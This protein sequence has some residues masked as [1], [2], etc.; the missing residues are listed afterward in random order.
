[1]QRGEPFGL[2]VLDLVYPQEPRQP[3]Q[4]T[5]AKS[6]TLPPQVNPQTRE[7]N[8][9]PNQQF[10]L[11]VEGADLRSRPVVDALFEAGCDDATIGSI[12]ETHHIDFDREAASMGAAILS[13][14]GDVQKVKGLR[15]TGVADVGRDLTDDLEPRTRCQTDGVGWLLP[16]APESG[17]FA[18]PRTDLLRILLWPDRTLRP[19]LEE[20]ATDRSPLIPSFNASPKIPRHHHTPP[21]ARQAS[22]RAR[23]QSLVAAALRASAI[24]GPLYSRST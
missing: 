12:D 3:C 18:S 17:G 1:M 23:A 24:R 8:P 10:T 21:A 6:Q 16:V 11:I 4:R 14:V 22:L 13:A 20:P 2:P 19:R 15:V 7:D 5:S 9:M